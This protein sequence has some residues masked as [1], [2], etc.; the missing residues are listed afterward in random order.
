MTETADTKP[1]DWAGN[2]RVLIAVWGLPLIVIFAGAFAGTT[3]RTIIWSLALLWM[4]GACLMNAKRCGRVHC[5]YT[6]PYY[7]ALII[8]VILQGT[9]QVSFGPYAWW[10][11]GA[12]ILFGG[13]I[14]WWI[15]E[16]RWGRYTN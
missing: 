2:I 13:K 15:T 3:L 7:L 5:R 4:G 11:L 16:S 10:V 1:K 8:P 14:I 12:A 9:G 6:G